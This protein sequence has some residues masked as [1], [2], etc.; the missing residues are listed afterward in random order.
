MR[1]PVRKILLVVSAVTIVG[2]GVGFAPASARAYHTS[3]ERILDNTAYSLHRRE[4]RLGLMQ[5]GYGI[6]DQLQITTYT[7]PWILGAI[8]QEVAPNLEL[9]STFYDERKLALSAA[10]G[11][12]TSTIQQTEDTKVRY[13]LVPVGV[14]SSVRINSDVSVHTGGI[15]T[16]TQFTGDTQPGG[17]EI[18]G[19]VVANLLQLTGTFEWRLSRVA[20]FT[21]N[22]RFTPYVS[23][24]VFHGSIGIDD[25]TS[26][27]IEVEQSL[28]DLKNTWAIVPGF[29]FSWERANLKLGVG[30][31]DL[32]LP[33]IGLVVPGAFPSPGIPSPIL[34]FDVFVRF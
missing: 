14:T 15:F 22:A 9:K 21:F 19:A 16:A 1:E 11:F 2:V 17:I 33:G 34:D 13:F 32:F 24:A 28:D 25:N 7:F 29:L 3:Q 4:V 18:E 8:F 20:A 30:Y 31:G 12:V 10:V 23:K 5:L 27:T 26:G 6:L